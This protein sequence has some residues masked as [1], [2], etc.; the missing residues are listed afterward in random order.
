MKCPKC[1]ESVLRRPAG[2]LGTTAPLRCPECRGFWFEASVLGSGEDPWGNPPAEDADAL[3]PAEG[4]G[5]RTTSESDGRA[6]AC[7]HGHGLLRRAHVPDLGFFLDRCSAC[8]GIWFDAGE[9]TAFARRHVRESLPSVWSETWQRAQR[10][11]RSEADHREWAERELGPELFARVE[12]L[13]EA[14]AG[15][16]RRS[17]ALAFLRLASSRRPSGAD[18]TPDSVGSRREP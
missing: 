3:S 6:G 12:E 7:P 18:R 5:E 16:P 11:R 8:H 13:A 15:H 4:C 14:L 9:W 10:A 1:R 17:E 2:T